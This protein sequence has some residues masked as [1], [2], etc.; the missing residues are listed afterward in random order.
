MILKNILGMKEGSVLFR[1]I[2]NI[3][4]E[5]RR[6]LYSAN[7]FAKM[8]GVSY[9]TNC[10][11]LTKNFGS[12][13]YLIEIG[14]NV[15]LSVDVTFVTH[16]GSLWV[17]R[18]LYEEYQNTDII[19]PIKIGNNVFI[20]AQSILLPGVI[21]GDNVIVGAGSLVNKKLESNYVYAGVPTRQICRIDDYIKKNKNDFMYIK[22]YSVNDKKNYLNSLKTTTLNN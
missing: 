5:I 12:E 9:G 17:I 16:D 4:K 22:N 15:E 10:K 20:G 2:F 14:N 8:T 7:E 6:K 21:I 11:F 18:N 3:I 13:P 1:R 19:K